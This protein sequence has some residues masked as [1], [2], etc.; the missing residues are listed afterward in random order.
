L[1]GRKK[2]TR[3]R[4]RELQKRGKEKFRKGLDYSSRPGSE[5]SGLTAI[6]TGSASIC[7]DQ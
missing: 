3:R 7:E 6:E 5:K 2:S 4:S 1:E